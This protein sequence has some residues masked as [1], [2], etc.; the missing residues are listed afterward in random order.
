MTWDGCRNRTTLMYF[1]KTG[2]LLE[3]TAQSG[4]SC[5]TLMAQGAFVVARGRATRPWDH[6]PK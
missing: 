6:S 3:L 2:A 4:L 5:D 1:A